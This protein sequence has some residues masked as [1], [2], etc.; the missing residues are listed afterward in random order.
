MFSPYARLGRPRAAAFTLVELLAVIAII[1]ILAALVIVALGKVRSSARQS[2]CLSN[3]RQIGVAWQLYLGDHNGRFPEFA[4]YQMY[5]WGGGAGT[6]GGPAPET[7]PLYPYISD[8]KFFRCPSDVENG[9][10]PPLY[11]FSGNSYV[12]ADS[13]QRGI[14]S[15]PEAKNRVAIT[16]YYKQLQ[17]PARTIM[18]YDHSARA[19]E[20]GY[21]SNPS[22]SYYRDNWH[23]NDTSNMLMADGHVETFQRDALTGHMAP[24]NPDGYT[25]GWSRFSGPDW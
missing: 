8:E 15:R 21:I 2:G 13:N 14:L 19:S 11:A 3:L 6:W 7:R 10:Q 1:G 25:W 24:L 16:G 20:P 22:A 9:A 23:T 4:T 18:V 17:H 12:M 5:Y